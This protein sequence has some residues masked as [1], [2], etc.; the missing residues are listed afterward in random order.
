MTDADWDSHMRRV[1]GP[2][3][4]AMA[5]DVQESWGDDVNPEIML[6]RWLCRRNGIQI[7]NASIRRGVQK[8]EE[9]LSS[10]ARNATS[11][12]SKSVDETRFGRIHS[13]EPPTEPP[14]SPT[15]DIA[16][17]E[18]GRTPSPWPDLP[19]SGRQTPSPGPAE[20]PDERP[21]SARLPKLKQSALPPLELNDG[22]G[23][24]KAKANNQKSPRQRSSLQT[25]STER[26][27][28][29]TL[30]NV[31]NHISSDQQR[32]RSRTQKMKATTDRLQE[33][34]ACAYQEMRGQ[35]LA[36]VPLLSSKVLETRQ[37]LKLVRKFHS[38]VYPPREPIFTEG[39]I[40]DRIYILERGTCDVIKKVNGRDVTVGQLGKGAFFGEIAVL[41]DMP[42]N[43]TVRGQ[44]EVSVL[45]LSRQDIQ[46]ELSQE[47]LDR[48]RLVARTQVFSSIPLFAKLSSEQKANVAQ[49]LRRQRFVKEACLA[50]PITV[51]SRIHIVE[52]GELLMQANDRTLLPSFMAEE[53]EIILKPG[54]YFGMRG[55]ISQAPNGFLI[56]VRSH[57]AWT[58]SISYEEL[59]QTAES[60]TERKAMAATMLRSMQAYWLGQIPQLKMLAE[61]A[62]ED[63]QRE[64][65]EVSFK[66]WAVIVKKGEPIEAVYVLESGKV[67]EYDGTYESMCEI[68]S[69]D[70][71][72]HERVI[73]GEFFGT[74]CLIKKSATAQHTLIALS[75][76]TMLKLYP[77]HV[78][79]VQEEARDFISKIPLF[80][81]DVL[82]QEEKPDMLQQFL[83]VA[84]LKQRSFTAG[85][86]VV[87]EGEIEDTLFVI[88]RGVC[89]A[90]KHVRGRE[91][92]IGQ[93][94]RGAFFGEIAAVFD[95]PRT[96][97]VRAGTAVTT[98]SL[99]REDIVS[100]IGDH[101]LG[102]M[103]LVAQ[104][105]VFGSIPLLANLSASAKIEIARGLRHHKFK[106]GHTIVESKDASERLFI[107]EKG[108]VAVIGRDGQRENILVAGMNFGMSRFLYQEPYG[109]KVVAESDAALLSL[110]LKDIY[111]TCSKSAQEA[112]ERK[113]QQEFRLWLLKEF[114]SR[115]MRGEVADYEREL[116]RCTVMK[117]ERGQAA[118]AKGDRLDSIYIAE[119]GSFSRGEGETDTTAVM[120][121]VAGPSPYV[122]G[123]EG[124]EMDGQGQ[125][126]RS[127]DLHATSNA[128]L[129]C[130]PLSV[131]S[132]R[133]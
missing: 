19:D 65:E 25:H 129:L 12:G 80:A 82:S 53:R 120:E 79:A 111:A 106:E 97:S 13:P 51:T 69:F 11:A 72:C 64:T 116:N 126:V 68:S 52:Q 36:K 59:L 49:A 123:L 128:S 109:M 133:R 56:T 118:F 4:Q 35:F 40:G 93:L 113:L 24:D 81:S 14:R 95:M 7:P 63:V 124:L 45:S 104:T 87:R 119:Y 1:I 76:V 61:E 3:L 22:S 8:D 16:R 127:Y 39:E 31:V 2:H 75:K 9:H 58:L 105:Q 37:Q 29:L 115:T 33:I 85:Q 41:Y 92:V 27:W 20:L 96:A 100:S 60:V 47:E 78:R 44:T 101:K 66:E 67:A 103:R 10:Q 130:M 21:H 99:S 6:L 54:Q 121:G 98:W 18:L 132:R 34:Y 73:P 43:A 107:V 48:M 55:L 83:L 114:F 110:T 102:T 94:S 108:Q 74:D 17:S 91:V 42:R 26:P 28:D 84:K 50:S 5:S 70:A 30:Q 90:C 88:D 15:P 23:F 131:L 46:E 77:S 32:H 57:E 122:F 71:D 89:D 125:S 86:Y 38:E 117:L 62:F 112:L